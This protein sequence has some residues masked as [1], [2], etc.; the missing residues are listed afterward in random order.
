MVPVAKSLYLHTMFTTLISA[1]QLA[2]HLNDPNWRVIDCR[3]SLADTEAGR[4]AY[5]QGHIPGALYAHLD[6]DL[7]API[8]PG[9]TGRHPLPDKDFMTQKFSSWGIDEGVQVVAYDDKTGMVA[10]RLW[11]M[12]RSLGHTRVAVLDGGFADWTAL[13]EASVSLD[14]PIVEPRKFHPGAQIGQVFSAD[15]VERI[16]QDAAFVLVDSR[17]AFRYRGESEPIDPVAGHIPGAVNAFFMENLDE[18]GRFLP[19]E[20]LRQRFLPLLDGRPAEQSVFYCGSGV[21]ACHNLLAIAHAGL[22]DAG[23][24]AGSWSEWITDPQRPVGGF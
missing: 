6:E 21:S 13:P 15:D 7:C 18:E 3:F 2:G 17:E 9:Q 12:L 23:L 5:A 24:Y 22:G 1:Q 11:W 19:A 20:Q 16:R 10:S 4:R 8:I 14:V